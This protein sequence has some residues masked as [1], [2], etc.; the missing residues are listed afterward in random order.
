MNEKS[1]PNEVSAQEKTAQQDKK[2]RRQPSKPKQQAASPAQGAKTRAPKPQPVKEVSEGKEAAPQQK[3]PRQPAPKSNNNNAANNSR[4]QAGNP[5]RHNTPHA[6]TGAAAVV[7]T[8]DATAAPKPPAR[9]PVRKQNFNVQ[10]R[11]PETNAVPIKIYPLGGLGEI[12]KNMTAYECN[13][14]MIVVDCGSLFPDSDMYGVDLVIPDFAFVEQNRDKL[15]G[16]VITHGHEDH[17]GALPYLFKEMSPPLYATRLTMGLIGNKLEEHG[18]RGGVKMTEIRPGEKFKL[19]CFTINPIHVNHSIPDAVA[20]AIESP[21]GVII[22]TGDYKVDFTPIGGPVTDLATIAEYGKNGVLALLSDSTNSERPGMSSSERKVNEGLAALFAKADK[23]RI[24]LATFASNLYRV[25]HI[26]ELAIKFG[27]KIAIS[28]RSMVN[29]TRMAL[30]LGYLKAP[31]EVMIDIEQINKYAPEEVVLITT[32]SQGEPL[33]ALSRMASGSHRNVH[34]GPEDFIIFS[35]TPI[36]GNEKMVTKVVNGLLKLGAEVIYENMYDVH[37]SGHACQE[38]QKMILNLARPK[39]FLP[40]HGE[41]KQLKRH[42]ATAE[43]MGMNKANIL[44]ADT[45]DCII[46]SKDAIRLG[47]PVQ[48]GAVMVDGLGVGDVGSVVLRDRRL[49]SQDGIVI[50]SAA[51]ESET[52]EL[53]SGPDVFSRGFVY[54]KESEQLMEEMRSAVL[55]LLENHRN[56]AYR[57]IGSLKTRVRETASSLLYRRT[58]R[59]PMI[60]PVVMEV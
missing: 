4:P 54:V 34:V 47:E 13:G 2:P 49:L 6:K 3:K 11:Q 23:K 5:P 32:G 33:A 41:Y 38:E 22:Q 15:R 7:R 28:G 36:P 25:Q 56:E 37:A 60:L 21:A 35:A 52:G 14:D 53:V 10:R 55:A 58:K 44:I 1:S 48:S 39:Y 43:A 16:V 17:I 20:F 19:G 18:L 31:P 46:L 40:V 12:G 30:E 51:V 24:I 9:K 50:I 8:G 29:N 57:D 45:G 27:R 42:A 26:M 59:S